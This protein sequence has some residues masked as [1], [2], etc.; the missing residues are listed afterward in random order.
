[1]SQTT[2]SRPRRADAQRNYDR[3][4]AETRQAVVEFGSDVA[5]EEIARRAGVGI[6]TLYRHFPTRQA[7]FEATFLDEAAELTEKAEDLL[8]EP[9]P[10][11]AL[12]QWFRAHMDMGIRSRS[13]GPSV[14]TAK[15]TEGTEIQLACVGMRE[16]GQRLIKRAQADGLVRPEVELTDVLRLLS[17]VLTA[18]QSQPDA[19]QLERMF[20]LVMAGIRA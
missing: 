16:A 2:T 6:G 11:A 5:L 8:T 10:M 18:N 12:E 7:L 3:I 20:Q 1:M 17:G 13:M 9:E 4:L 15:H 14:L 19:D